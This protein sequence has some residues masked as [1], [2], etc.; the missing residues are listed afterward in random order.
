MK[1]VRIFLGLSALTV[2]V[3]LISSKIIMAQPGAKK[4]CIYPKYKA[5][6]DVELSDLK[7]KDA[8]CFDD[9]ETLRVFNSAKPSVL[10]FTLSQ[11][12]GDIGTFVD[13]NNKVHLIRIVS[14][15]GIIRDDTSNK[16]YTIKDGD[17]Q[18]KWYQIITEATLQILKDGK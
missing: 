14:T 12:G 8:V 3:I 11:G 7:P 6:S 18:A 13:E 16:T 9:I 5:S 15:N 4:L 2:V 10:S 17:M 1:N